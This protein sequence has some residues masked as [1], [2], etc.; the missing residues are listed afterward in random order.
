MIARARMTG[1][2]LRD[3]LAVL[4][5]TAADLGLLT[6]VPE[7]RVLRWLHEEETVPPWLRGYCAA[8]TIPEAKARAIEAIGR[9]R[10]TMIQNAGTIHLRKS[11]PTKPR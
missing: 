4:A 2:E 3:A 1:Q 10:P 11:L 8:L 6:S 7:R 9:T 5:L